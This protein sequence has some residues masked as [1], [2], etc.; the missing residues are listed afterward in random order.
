MGWFCNGWDHWSCVVDWHILGCPGVLRWLS[1][2]IIG[3]CVGLI[4][5]WW[6]MPVEPNVA[7]WTLLAPASPWRPACCCH[8]KGSK[9]GFGDCICEYCWL[10][11][12][13][14]PGCSQRLM[15][16]NEGICVGSCSA[17]EIWFADG[18]DEARLALVPCTF[19][20]GT[21]FWTKAPFSHA[22]AWFKS[23]KF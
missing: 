15:L 20:E 5:G 21:L 18:W 3:L 9:T 11:K 13:A 16:I 23:P 7:L 1:I 14:K 6:E 10:N 17:L 2:C 12:F 4:G 8:A 19:R 22:E